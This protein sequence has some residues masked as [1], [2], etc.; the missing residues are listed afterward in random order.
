MLRV[1]TIYARSA[2]AAA[3]YYTRYLTE[4]P[5]EAPGQWTGAQAAGLGL[6]G[7]VAGDDLLAVLEGRDPR[8]GTPLGR[9]RCDRVHADGTVV[10]AVA[11]FDATFSAPKSLSVLW[12]LT[13]DE[14]LLEAHDVAVA[15]ALAHLERFGSTT[16][17]RVTGG[18][19]H[20]DSQ[21][22]TIAAFRQTTSRA[23]DPQIHTHCVVSAKAQTD[24]GRWLALDARYLKRHQRMLGGLYQS[25]LRNEL[26]RQ[27][28]IAWGPIEQGQAEMRAMPPELLDLFSKRSG[29]IDR[30]L[31]DKISGFVD[32]HGRDPNQWELGALKREAAVDTRRHKSGAG[33][34]GLVT[35]WAEEA[36]SIGWDAD[37]LVDAIEVDPIGHDRSTLSLDAVIERL[38]ASGST[39]NR[40]QIIEAITDLARPDPTSDGAHWAARIEASADVLTARCVELDPDGDDGP[41]RRSDGRSLWLEPIAPHITSEAILAEEEWIATWSMH[42]QTEDPRPSATVTAK[43]LDVLQ[44]D[45]AAAVAGDDRL[46]L[47]VGPAGAG[48]TTTLRAAVDDLVRAGRP[49][50]GVAP[51]AKGAR[52]LATETGIATDTLAKLLHE[53]QRTD[54]PPGPAHRLPAGTTIIVD[55]AGMVGTNSLASLTRLADQQGWR[56]ALVGDPRQLQAVGRGGMFHELC[57]TGRV[58]E[59]SRIHRFTNDWEAA[60]SLRLRHGDPRALDAYLAHDRIVAGTFETQLS[61]ITA[62][63]RAVRAEGGTCA[64]TASSNDHVDAINVEV[65]AARLAAGEIDGTRVAAIGHGEH[66]HPGEVVVTR[67][68]DRRLA[69]SVGEPVRNR[70]AWTVIDVGADGSITVSSMRGSG[71]VELPPEYVRQHVRLGYAA[72]EHGNQGDTTTIGIE[73]VSDATTRRGLYVGATRGRNENLILVVTASSDLDEARDVLERVLANDRADLPAIAQ[74]RSLAEAVRSIPPRARPSTQPTPR[75]GKSIDEPVAAADRQPKPVDA[76]PRRHDEQRARL[77]EAIHAARQRRAAAEAVL[78]PHRSALAAAHLDVE[79]AREQVWSSTVALQR[80]ST[81][82]RRGARRDLT[83]AEADLDA[84]IRQQQRVEHAAQP[85]KQAL[86]T[87]DADLR[88]L[89]QQLHR[90]DLADRMTVGHDRHVSE[91]IE[92]PPLQRRSGP[93]LEL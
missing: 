73:L 32:R 2:H 16:R 59:L 29:Q 27:L 74:R 84:A 5:G 57:T 17:V 93:T 24:D 4:S 65:Q 25:V 37:R 75:S 88:R 89:E 60:A 18:R 9:V 51:S 53:W 69:T 35:R 52:V 49:V 55:E 8:T 42:V 86:A 48:K 71:T 23:D 85:A 1:R 20:P 46:V 78:Q 30:A 76:H 58:H 10:R 90:L 14:R 63:W 43:H 33:V 77:V 34:D 26:A 21:G 66:A 28:G 13:Q 68:N 40:A 81:L 67:R 7:E 80:S 41:K 56:L 61:F 92:P 12:A 83:T 79:A 39:W 45:V 54:R 72:T 47:V 15:A 6:T 36:A 11:G 87:A 22:L 82:K 3:N 19:L 50:Y 62:R 64:I 38:S 31:A 91:A 44:R 70:E